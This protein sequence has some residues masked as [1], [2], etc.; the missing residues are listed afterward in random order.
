VPCSV[1]GVGHQ[2]RWLG[3]LRLNG[4]C[5][6]AGFFR[7]KSLSEPFR[8][9]GRTILSSHAR[10]YAREES[11]RLCRLRA[12]PL[13]QLSPL[14]DL[15]KLMALTAVPTLDHV[16]IEPTATCDLD[17]PAICGRSY[18]K[19]QRV[20]SRRNT[21]FMPMELFTRIVDGF[22]RP[23]RVIG[24][25]NYGEPLLHPAFATMCKMARTRCPNSY[26][27]TSTNG[28]R[29][30]DPGVRRGLLESGL[31]DII[32]SVDGATQET[33][34]A[35][36]RGGRLDAILDGM[37][38][39]R[40]ERERLGSRRPRLLWRYLLFAWNDGEE[41]LAQAERLA[42]DIGV[43]GFGYALSDLPDLASRTYVPGAPAFE[44]IRGRM[45]VQKAADS[46][47]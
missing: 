29:L 17:C 34:G 28:T 38:R 5:A 4:L 44:R 11:E 30:A 3:G 47:S 39:F 1:P 41:E 42:R 8:H 21:R 19:A 16:L 27:Y 13:S 10:A 9:L 43:D 37:R 31:D 45:F 24:F 33:Y 18:P 2:L 14:T 36:R 22:D 15:E 32:V 12:V 46:S 7:Y 40:E 20:V 23:V 26:I 35:Y 6:A 25:Y